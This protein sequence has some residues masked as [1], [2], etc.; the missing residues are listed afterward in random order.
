[1]SD[2]RPDPDALLARV[3]AEQPQP[4][5]GRL[6]IFF[7]MSAGVGKTYA[8][9]QEAQER[10]RSGTDVVA[11]Y[12]ETHKRPETDALRTGLEELPPRWV[13]YRGV[14]LREFDLDAALARK[15]G[16]ILV[17]ELAHT[18][19]EG[20]RHIKRCQDVLELLDAGID[21][22]TTVNVQH[23][24]SL[25]DVVAQITGIPVRETVP[26]SIIERGDE[27]ELVDIPPDDLI[28]RL[29]E[30]K[31]YIADQVQ[32][33]V[34]QFFRR[35]NL[36]ALRELALRE[37]A[38][39]VGEQ[40]RVERA[41]RGE[42]KPWA[43]SD[44]LLVCVGPS[45]LSARVIRIARRMAAAAQA[46]WVAVSVETP[47]QSELASA[48]VRRNLKLAEQL[49]AEPAVLTGERVVDELLAY[50]VRH[51]ITKI[52]IGKPSLPRWR[53]WL[54][55]S[56]VDE[57]IRR[58][59]EIDVHVVKGEPEQVVGALPRVTRRVAT[60]QHY[61]V[62]A[63]VMSACTGVSALLSPYLSAVNLT[64]I[65]LAGVVFIGTRY[66]AGPSALASVL[67]ALLFNFVF[68]EPYYTFAITDPTLIIT[69]VTLLVTGLIVS[70]L[71]QRVRRQAEAIR[72]RY[73]RTFALY[74]MSRQLAA[75]ASGESLARAAARHVAD[76][77]QGDTVV[78]V[79]DSQHQLAAAAQSGSFAAGPTNERA[80]AQWVFEH[81]KWAGWST[82]TLPASAAI[83]LPLVA[84]GRSLGVLALHPRQPERPLEPDQ[85]HMLE[86]FATQLAIA[87]ERAAFASEAETARR[88][89]ETEQVRSS[90]LSCVSHDLRTPL[91]AI[92]GAASAL[93]DDLPQLTDSMRREL[94]Q[95]I[96]EEAGRL[97]QLVAKLLDMTRLESAGFRLQKDWYPLDEL[98]G[99]ALTRLSSG[100]RK[101]NVR[102]EIPADLP[103]LQADGPLIE[104][105]LGNL[106]ENAARYTP[107]GSSITIRAG[108]AA[109]GV[110]IEVIDDGPGLQPGTEKE[111]F[112][113]F[114][115]HR[116]RSDRQGTGLGLA[117]CEAVVRLHG[118]EIGA[119]NRPEGGARFWFRLPM[120]SHAPIVGRDSAESIPPTQPTAPEA[121]L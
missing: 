75:A 30:G 56:I 88:E 82:D 42:T 87:L 25:N 89:A 86:T 115:R 65:Y 28:Q 24:E 49:G 74:F 9:L 81:K 27:I 3:E 60:W 119:E 43:T 100:L 94:A 19:A 16:L 10:R 83:Y 116:P 70:G 12:I 85:R 120:G 106:L 96:A 47:G 57:L 91:A 108:T 53:E 48:Q 14:R 36:V 31:V 112:R 50:A 32:R 7:G 80:A 109:S 66:S 18:N 95:S 41:G 21:V 63:A 2:Q 34:Q 5:R 33:A 67:A 99:A 11:G 52:V 6:K 93:V 114:V 15:P 77:F 97:N 110:L 90:L 51:N 23:I 78:L 59:G 64:M 61:G 105:T 4:H 79:P 13:E 39:R 54:R 68:T 44:R 71:T 20:S 76:V 22:Y 104:E 103:L 73:H 26:D 117:I 101:H 38:A 92:A 17:D 107:P 37:T 40:V 121:V 62:A 58:S 29:R 45:P 102:T 8:M 113:R 1:M 72:T 111:I 55:G 118:G 46:E 35:E 69:F 98:V 84:S